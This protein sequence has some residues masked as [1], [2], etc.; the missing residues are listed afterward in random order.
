MTF[1]QGIHQ[2]DPLEQSQLFRSQMYEMYTDTSI[3]ISFDEIDNYL[4]SGS[5]DILNVVEMKDDCSSR[6]PLRC[7]RRVMFF[8]AV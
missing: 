7:F 1:P 6:G 3:G 8:S 4:K 2:S 5:V